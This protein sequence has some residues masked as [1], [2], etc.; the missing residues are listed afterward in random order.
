MILLTIKHHRIFVFAKLAALY[1][2]R[3]LNLLLRN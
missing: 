3:C 2:N 1:T